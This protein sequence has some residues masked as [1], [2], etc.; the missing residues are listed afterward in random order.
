MVGGG[1]WGGQTRTLSPFPT[2]GRNFGT[3]ELQNREMVRYALK[4]EV[5]QIGTLFETEQLPAEG[6]GDHLDEHAK[7]QQLLGPRD[8][9]PVKRWRSPDGSIIAYVIRQYHF[10]EEQGASY[11]L[12]VEGHLVQFED[13]VNALPGGR[14]ARDIGGI[15]IAEALD[16][17]R[18]LVARLMN[19]FVAFAILDGG[20]SPARNVTVRLG[21]LKWTVVPDDPAPT[22]KPAAHRRTRTAPGGPESS[23]TLLIKSPLAAA[24]LF[25][26]A[27]VLTRSQLLTVTSSSLAMAFSGYWL[28]NRLGTF[29]AS[30]KLVP[31]IVGKRVSKNILRDVALLLKPIF[32][33]AN[34]RAVVTDRIRLT[35]RPLDALGE[36]YEIRVR[37]ATGRAIQSLRIQDIDDF[38][39]PGLSELSEE[40]RNIVLDWHTIDEY[41]PPIE[42]DGL[43]RDQETAVTWRGAPGFAPIAAQATLL[44]RF[45]DNPGEIAEKL[46]APVGVAQPPPAISPDPSMPRG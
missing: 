7:L 39:A 41:F 46:A 11:A 40:E 35:V 8:R 24:V 2:I 23:G 37:N 16:G 19:D 27:I 17:R 9:T 12:F 42:F 13:S 4:D 29:D 30:K 14:F 45:V 38:L 10:R 33:E 25:V 44:V 3:I 36:R 26:G 22:P 18:S 32:D 21:S 20:V 6:T 31:W 28:F 34:Q 15:R 1:A 43:Q 5:M